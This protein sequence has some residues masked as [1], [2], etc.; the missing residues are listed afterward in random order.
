MGPFL[1][2]LQYDNG[3]KGVIQ[4]EVLHGDSSYLGVGNLETENNAIF[5]NSCPTFFLGRLVSMIH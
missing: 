1:G 5:R 2:L 3:G 4:K